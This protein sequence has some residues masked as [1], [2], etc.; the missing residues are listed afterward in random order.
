M[1]RE[2]LLVLE[3][4]LLQLGRLVVAL[5]LAHVGLF[6]VAWVALGFIQSLRGTPAIL[7]VLM[8]STSGTPVFGFSRSWVLPP[9]AAVR[10]VALSTH[11]GVPATVVL[12]EVDTAKHQRIAR[13]RSTSSPV[14]TG[15][16]SVLKSALHWVPIVGIAIV[17]AKYPCRE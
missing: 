16:A 4:M 12:S 9:R 15:L 17:I 8:L 2:E 11:L 1:K 13:D 6:F 7:Y 10:F 14:L 3:F 5:I